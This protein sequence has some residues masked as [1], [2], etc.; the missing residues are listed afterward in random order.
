MISDG[1]PSVE[2]SSRSECA[3]GRL[4]NRLLLSFVI[5][6]PY[7]GVPVSIQSLSA[8]SVNRRTPV[9]FVVFCQCASLGGE[10][11]RILVSSPAYISAVTTNK[12]IAL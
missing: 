6:G 4:L 5:S 9:A 1:F 12:P 7:N 11:G 10:N 3:D 8:Q 2:I